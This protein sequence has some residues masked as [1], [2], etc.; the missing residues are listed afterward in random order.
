M[1]KVVPTL[2]ICP[3]KNLKGLSTF[4]QVR[5]AT[6]KIKKNPLLKIKENGLDVAPP[7]YV[8]IFLMGE[9]VPPIFQGGGR[10]PPP[11]LSRLCL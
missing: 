2:K 8:L 3:G 9:D 7:L 1:W 4:R 11:P 10:P 5:V 6:G